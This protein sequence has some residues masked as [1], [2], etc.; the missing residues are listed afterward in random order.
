MEGL[1]TTLLIVALFVLLGSGVWIGLM[2]SGVACAYDDGHPIEEGLRLA[3]AA[4]TAVVITPGTG[5][6]HRADVAA[7]LPQVRLE[8]IE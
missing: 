6:C 5:E 2:L 3:V 7:F 1:V 8:P 4:A